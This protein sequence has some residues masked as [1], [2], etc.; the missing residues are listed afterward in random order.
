MSE[1][2]ALLAGWALAAILI[3]AAGAFVTR[4]RR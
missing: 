3:G 4:G 2:E 1:G